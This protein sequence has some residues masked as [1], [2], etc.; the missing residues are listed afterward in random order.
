MW[1]RIIALLNNE[2]I[3]QYIR[4]FI[5]NSDCIYDS[6]H[7]SL[8]GSNLV[9]YFSSFLHGGD[10]FFETHHVKSVSDMFK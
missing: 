10:W 8:H 1:F 5:K 7:Y 3:F 2:C 6:Q 9:P 4:L